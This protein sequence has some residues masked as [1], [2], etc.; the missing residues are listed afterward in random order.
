MVVSRYIEPVSGPQAKKEARRP[1]RRGEPEDDAASV[2]DR[3]QDDARKDALQ[4]ALSKLP[5][6][7][8]E[9]VIL[10]H[11]EELSNPE[12]AGVMGISVE[13]V[14][15]LTARGKRALTA[16]LAGRKDELGYGDG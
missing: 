12:I 16:I 6:R 7:Q 13:A 11:I 5:D 3:M 15:S 14:E 2:V 9:A 8:R 4:V 10:R 1:E